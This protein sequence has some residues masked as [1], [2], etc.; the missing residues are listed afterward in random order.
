MPPARHPPDRAAAIAAMLFTMLVWGLGPVFIRSLATTLGPA[1][2]MVIRYALVSLVYAAG[3]LFAGGPRI[4]RQDWPRLLAVSLVGMLGYN[5]GSVYGFELL[6]AGLGGLIIGTQPLLIVFTAALVAGEV[7]RPAAFAGVIV[8]F[9][10]TALL[11][12]SDV[13]IEPEAG[14]HLRGAIYIFLSGACWALYVVLARPLIRKHGAYPITA[15]S[16]VIA[17]V[18]MLAFA[19]PATLG[20][21]AGMSARSWAE[22]FYMVVPS[23]LLATT[24]FNFGVGR[25][26]S[27]AA[28]AF[29]YLVPVVA[30]IAGAVLLGEKVTWNV[31]AG[32]ALVL[33]GV[34]LAEFAD[35]WIER[36]RRL[37]GSRFT[38]A[39]REREN[40]K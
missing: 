11:F 40:P 31:L 15:L 6:P 28:G 18:P 1:D 33:F 17:T 10:G 39:V 20:T 35:R 23:T 16:I 38:A 27:A 8:A 22:M 32:G 3:F 24:A 7:I 9:A 36:V 14:S 13:T 26:S 12:L 37:A 34:A 19:S 29:L 2:S 5:L 4:E 25:L 30:V 21:A